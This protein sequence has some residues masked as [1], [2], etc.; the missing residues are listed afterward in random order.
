MKRLVCIVMLAAACGCSPKI[1]EKV[2]TEIEYRDRYVH[3]TTEVKIPYEVE[4]I[5]TR[6]TVSHLENTYAKSDA[7]VSEGFLSHSL[8]SKP[9][10]I[11][12]PVEVHVTDTIIKESEIKTE[13]KYVEKPLSWWKTTQIRGFWVLSGILAFWLCVKLR[14][15]LKNGI[16]K[17]L[18]LLHI[19]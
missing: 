11:K 16:V 4:K 2:V 3:D 5:V 8:E 18:Q 9:Q 1:I 10:I 7:V 17:L 13:I 6:D 19:I 15:P 12:V 14:K